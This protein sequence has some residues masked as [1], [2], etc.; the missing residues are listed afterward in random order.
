MLILFHFICLF[1]YVKGI[2]MTLTSK[3]IFK[4]VMFIYNALLRITCYPLI[5]AG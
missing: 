4:K 1:I 5:D 2:K 3:K